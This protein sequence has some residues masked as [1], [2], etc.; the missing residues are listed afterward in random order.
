MGVENRVGGLPDVCAP[1]SSTINT[2]V[3]NPLPPISRTEM[4]DIGGGAEAMLVTTI[5]EDRGAF[6]N[7]MEIA[8][9]GSPVSVTEFKYR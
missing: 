8:L 2:I 6:L 9:G 5:P 7:F 3:L 4:A 1:W